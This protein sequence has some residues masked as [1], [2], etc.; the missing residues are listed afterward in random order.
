MVER[1]DGNRESVVTFVQI[2]SDNTS[3]DAK[4]Q[5]VGDLSCTC[6]PLKCL[7]KNK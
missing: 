3:D 4:D 5:S 6:H 1:G 2:F 7:T